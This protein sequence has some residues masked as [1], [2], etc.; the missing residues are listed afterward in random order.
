MKHRD[1]VASVCAFSG[2]LCAGLAVSGR[3]MYNLLTAVLGSI[4]SA[5]LAP[6]LRCALGI[7]LSRNRLMQQEQLS[8]FLLILLSIC[9]VRALPYI[10]SFAGT[11]L[12]VLLTLFCA[13][14]GSGMGAMGGIAAGSALMLGGSPM[15]IGSALSLCGL[16]AGVVCALPRACAAAVMLL[17]NMLT[18]SW[19]IGGSSGMID[20]AALLAGGILYCLFPPSLLAHLRKWMLPPLFQ[21]DAERMSVFLRRR[22]AQK[23]DALG[24]V[25]G[26]IADGYGQKP[27]L[28]GEQQIIVRMRQALCDGCEGYA[29]CWQGEKPQAGRLMCRLMAQSMQG[30]QPIRISE[31][32]PDLLRHCRRSSQLETRVMPLLRKLSAQRTDALKRGESRSLL[33]AQLRQAQQ[34]VTAL[35]MQMKSEFCLSAEYAQLAHAA[36][37]RAGL[38]VRNVTA[39]LDDRIELICLMRGNLWDEKTARLAA[40]AV[41]RHMGVPF[42]PVLSHGRAAGE[43]E[44]RLL[45][46]PALSAVI[47]ARCISAQS[48]TPCGDSHIAC[49]LSDGRLL[50]A[51]S[52]GMGHGEQAAEESQKC[53][54]LIRKFI[55][56]DIEHKTALSSVNRLLLLRD[57]EEMFATV[58]LCEINLYSGIARFSKLSANRTF[59]LKEKETLTV[60]G[61]R[62]PLGILE[63]VEPAEASV[64]VY[65]GD[66]VI[67]TSDGIADELKDGQMDELQ[68]LAAPLRTLAPDEIA[69]RI[70]AW[71]QARDGEKDDMTVIVFRILQRC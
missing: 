70:L 67:M 68:A 9:G 1:A 65:P 62:L 51:I 50:A 43:W 42:S 20:P 24:D 37:D 45:Q 5:L 30:R 16:L 7:R 33:S 11:A 69:A 49:L 25:F 61:G 54:S 38:N 59:I 2:L 56:A 52:D 60:T 44:L 12:C 53:I 46:A 41:S 23:L 15:F 6:C 27:S 3:L 71:A 19:G 21:P 35:S 31:L 34:A 66:V 26:E 55:C 48:G 36:L 28:P 22:A 14:S 58:D 29:E 47:A 57:G 40:R 10:G 32:P 17:G 63:S 13:S 64:E 18:V 4:A 8:L 39:L